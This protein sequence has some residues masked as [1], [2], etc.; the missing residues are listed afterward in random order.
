MLT[1]ENFH[2]DQKENKKCFNG[3]EIGRF[4][5][6]NGNITPEK[7]VVPVG[8]SV[9]WLS[10]SSARMA[11]DVVKPHMYQFR[12]TT[13]LIQTGKQEVYCKRFQESVANGFLD[14]KMFFSDEA[15]LH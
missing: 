1:M 12:A 3:R 11:I 13:P 4:W 2:V 7:S 8:H 5:L 6:L 10:M 14:T 15:G 9:D